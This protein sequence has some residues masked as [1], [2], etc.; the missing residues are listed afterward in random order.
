MVLSSGIG[1][2]LYYFAFVFL[3]NSY[4]I[5]VSFSI[6]TVLFCITVLITKLVTKQDLKFVYDLFRNYFG[7]VYV[8]LKG[9]FRS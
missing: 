3:S 4:N 2:I 1:A 9:M 6:G 5:L 8:N 7:G